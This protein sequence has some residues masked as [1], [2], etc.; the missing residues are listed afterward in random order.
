MKSEPTEARYN[1][2]TGSIGDE[3]GDEIILR[4]D[5]E[6]AVSIAFKEGQS[7]PKIKQLEWVLERDDWHIS[8]TRFGVSY[9]I[10]ESKNDGNFFLYDILLTTTIHA[11]I[12]AAKAA[13]QTDFEQHVKECL[14]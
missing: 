4:E 13:A 3:Y 2:M 6:E 7:N 10:V 5:A 12:E 1:I 14:L 9:E 11:T 8:M